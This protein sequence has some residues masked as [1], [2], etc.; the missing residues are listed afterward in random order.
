MGRGRKPLEEAP[1]Q[2]PVEI[3]E[4]CVG[5]DRET[6]RCC[7]KSGKVN[8]YKCHSF[9]TPEQY[10]DKLIKAR[11][12]LAS[13]PKSQQITIAETYHRGKMPWLNYKED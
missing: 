12:R 3:K 9:E 8:C 10:R 13:L 2:G 7:R 1:I 11:K 6:H 4:N 5:Y